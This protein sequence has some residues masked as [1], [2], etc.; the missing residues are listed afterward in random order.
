MDRK[1]FLKACGG[2]CLGLI[3]IAT[4]LESGA[5]APHIQRSAPDHKLT[6]QE[7]DFLYTKG[8]KIKHHPHLIVRV[9]QVPFPIVVY[10]HSATA[11]TALLL[12]CTHQG[13]ELNVNGN[14][15]TCPAHGSEFDS[16]GHIVQ[17]PAEQPLT[18]FP[19]SL[20]GTNIQIQLS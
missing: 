12:R 3:S 19:V 4:L 7:Q 2:T 9:E 6:L 8:D 14:I 11:Y 18:T 10:R 13:S 17:G 5:P 20:D 15:L 16:K 1:H